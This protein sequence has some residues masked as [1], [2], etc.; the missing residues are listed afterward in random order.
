MIL[1]AQKDVE[2]MTGMVLELHE[3]HDTKSERQN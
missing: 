1:K 3:L 2:R